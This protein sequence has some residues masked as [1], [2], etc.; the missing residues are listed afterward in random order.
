[1]ILS[2]VFDNVFYDAQRQ[3]RI[4]FYM[5][6]FGEEATHFGSAA[7][8]TLEDCVFTQY[9]ELGV[10]I[11]RGADLQMLADTN[12]SNARGHGLGRQMPVHYGHTES[13]I[14]TVSSPLGTQMPHAAGAAYA[15]KLAK[16]KIAT[17][18][19][20]GEGA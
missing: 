17:I 6:N 10:F 9:R 11:Q 4:S 8:L 12:F 14:F 5:T 1:M 15:N 20:F 13:N 3:G 7:A 18:C 19:F 2:N 16:K